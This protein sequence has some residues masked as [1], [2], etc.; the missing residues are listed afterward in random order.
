M[1]SVEVWLGNAQCSN[2]AA[3]SR[4]IRGDILSCTV[5]N[6]E[7][8]YYHVD[9]YVRGKGH[10]S[11]HP[12]ALH[13]G[14]TRNTT[15]SASESSLYPHAFLEGVIDSLSPNAGS[16]LGGTLLTLQ[17]SG[18]SISTERVSVRVGEVPCSVISSSNSEISCITG[19]STAPD[20]DHTVRLGATIN[21]YPATT[22]LHFMYS[23][24]STPV[25]SSLSTRQAA[26]GDN[27]VISGTNFGTS[28]VVQIVP[29]LESFER[30]QAE[31]E[32]VVVFSSDTEITCTLPAKPAGR[33]Q[34]LVIVEQLGYARPE[35]EG[36]AVVTYALRVD[37]FSPREGGYGGGLVLTVQ[38]QGFPTGTDAEGINITLCETYC[39]VTNSN[40]STISCILAPSMVPPSPNATLSCNLTFSY[41]GMEATSSENFLL[42]DSLTPRLSSITPSLGGTAGG[43]RVTLQGSGFLPPAMTSSDQLQRGD[44]VVSIDGAVCDWTNLN[45]TDGEIECLTGSHRTTL[46]A[47]VEV[48]VRGKGAA[49]HESGAVL[50]EYIDLWSSRFT[51][52]GE[53]LPA[54]GESVYIRTGQTVFLDIS[55]P[56]LNLILI[57]GTLLFSDTQD[58][59]LQAKYIFVNNGTLQV[60]M[61]PKTPVLMCC[62]DIAVP[63]TGGH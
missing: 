12:M 41:N 46:K 33:R 59:H 18:F 21:G 13:P 56:Q 22:D 8:E 43:T 47:R 53:D 57:E 32:C 28:P 5:P 25:M 63:F 30:V 23:L 17:G 20:T 9:V 7:S 38:G 49:L 4:N 3:L 6:Y 40:F 10:A 62:A 2:V 39:S 42:L 55:P 35:M 27:I 58:L 15:I 29:S 52:G 51:W 19:P 44:I 1:D 31:D 14:R 34:V 36:G 11:V 61:S 60:C 26:G 16:V 50:F 37:E 48:T 45:V 24:A 54:R